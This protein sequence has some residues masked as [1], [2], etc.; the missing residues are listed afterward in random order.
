MGRWGRRWQ[1]DRGR[2]IHEMNGECARNRA[3]FRSRYRRRRK[4]PRARSFSSARRR[5]EIL[6]CLI[7]I[8]GSF[9]AS[10]EKGHRYHVL[11][12]VVSIGMVLKG[13]FLSMIL[14]AA[15]WVAISID[16]ICSILSLTWGWS[17]VPLLPL[18]GHG[19]QQEKRLWR[20][21]FQRYREPRFPSSLTGVPC[22]RV[23]CRPIW[24]QSRGWA[25]LFAAQG[26]EG[27]LKASC[28]G[29]AAANS[30]LIL[31]WGHVYRCVKGHCHDRLAYASAIWSSV[32]PSIFVATATHAILTRKTWLNRSGWSYFQ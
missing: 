29:I 17:W 4:G 32:P 10:F 12:A 30:F 31:C 28:S 2:C 15:S 8:I 6:R 3:L 19:I 26:E 7:A 9:K 13:P 11:H 16:A 25:Y 23:S 20:G 14:M 24:R 21:C 18:F 27:K 22:S 1:R 5:F